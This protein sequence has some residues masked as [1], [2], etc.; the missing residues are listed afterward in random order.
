MSKIKWPRRN[1]GS[2]SENWGRSVEQNIEALSR[3]QEQQQQANDNNNKQVNAAIN[4]LQGIVSD[5]QETTEQ[6][7][8]Q[9]AQ[10]LAII[11]KLIVVRNYNNYG[12]LTNINQ[13]QWYYTAH[14]SITVPEGYNSC[15]ALNINSASGSSL[16]SNPWGAWVHSFIY[17]PTNSNYGAGGQVG[18]SNA[19]DP[20][21][22][23][24]VF[25]RTL[26][27]LSA[28]DT[29]YGAAGVW[30]SLLGPSAAGG[31]LQV[32]NSLVCFFFNE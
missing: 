24:A 20:G 9:Q 14:C 25:S 32:M 29:V 10:I 31:Q 13:F 6:L 22:A 12:T 28:G 11:D 30:Q 7:A 27:G 8:E 3:A 16:D 18:S 5:L 4:S 23:S 17:T 19:A 15:I 1:L 26:T 21:S 2:Q